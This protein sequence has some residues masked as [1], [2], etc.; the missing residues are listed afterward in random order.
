MKE[1]IKPCALDVKGNFDFTPLTKSLLII[2]LIFLGGCGPIWKGGFDKRY[3]SSPIYIDPTKKEIERALKGIYRI[4]TITRFSLGDSIQT[5]RAVGH[6]IA[7]DEHNLL[8]AKHVVKI[9][10]FRTFSPFGFIEIPLPEKDKVEEK[11]FILEED[12]TRVEVKRIYSD[13][14]RDFAKLRAHKKLTPFPFPMGNSAELQIGN[15]VFLLGDFQTG[16]CVRMGNVTQLTFTTYGPN[17]EV[18][19]IDND[20]IGISATTVGGD[21]GAPIVSVRDGKFELIGVVT[22]FVEQARGI[23]YGL[24]IN[25]IVD[26]L[27]ESQKVRRSSP[28]GIQDMAQPSLDAI[29]NGYSQN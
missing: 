29:K 15:V 26:R 2:S 4:E 28:F 27:K 22:F 18:A 11:S 9:D 7:L 12:G 25:A 3:D 14:D 19:H 21:S 23:G 17:G 24:K 6:A 16:F 8:T 1:N 5:T 20:I 10:S 13:D